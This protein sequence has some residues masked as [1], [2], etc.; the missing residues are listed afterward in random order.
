MARPRGFWQRPIP[1]LARD[2]TGE[3]VPLRHGHIAIRRDGRTR[4]LH[5]L[6]WEHFNGPIPT[7]KQIDHINGVRTDN[8]I[9]NLRIVSPVENNRNLARYCNN[10]S[11][12]VGVVLSATRPGRS[13]WVAYW[14]DN[15]RKHRGKSFR[16]ERLGDA[17]AKRQ[18]TEYRAARIAELGNYTERHGH[19]DEAQGTGESAGATVQRSSPSRGTRSKRP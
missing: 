18:A 9:E 17:E 11:G 2:W 13:Y 10:T 5:R 6:V 8:R 7:D 15:F 19:E 3:K 14:Y 16:I 12:A 1:E 4:Y